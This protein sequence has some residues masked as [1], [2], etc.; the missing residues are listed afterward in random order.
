MVA[1]LDRA[2][3][4]ALDAR[5]T[6]RRERLAEYNAIHFPRKMGT[7]RAIATR[8]GAALRHRF[9]AAVTSVRSLTRRA[10]PKGSI[11]PRQQAKSA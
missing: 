11:A 5:I 10:V 7:V 9:A 3:V 4:A 1:P 8:W 2:G 6:E